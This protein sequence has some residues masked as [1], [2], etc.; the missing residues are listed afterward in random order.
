[1]VLDFARLAKVTG[2][3]FSR[4]ASI[5]NAADVRPIEV[6]ANLLDDDATSVVLAY[7]EGWAENE[8]RRLHDLVRNHPAG[9]PVVILKPGRSEVGRKAALSHTGSLAR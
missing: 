4:C 5:G 8:G 9:K 2:S 7:L 6:I 1:M 3:G